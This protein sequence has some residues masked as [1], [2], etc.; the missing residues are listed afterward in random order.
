MHLQVLYSSIHVK[1]IFKNIICT[2]HQLFSMQA[3]QLP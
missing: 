1:F 2:C 3:K